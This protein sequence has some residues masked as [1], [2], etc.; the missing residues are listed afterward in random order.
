MTDPRDVLGDDDGRLM[1]R[2]TTGV[3]WRRLL[4]T[5]AG[6]ETRRPQPPHRHLYM[7]LMKPYDDC[8]LSHNRR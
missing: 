4:E 1:P 3:Y 8:C 7:R 6:R 2:E 5:A